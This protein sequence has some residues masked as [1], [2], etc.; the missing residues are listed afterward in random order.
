[1]TTWHSIKNQFPMTTWTWPSP[2]PQVGCTDKQRCAIILWSAHEHSEYVLN[3][4]HFCHSRQLHWYCKAERPPTF[5]SAKY[6][7]RPR[8]SRQGLD[9]NCCVSNPRSY[10][11]APKSSPRKLLGGALSYSN[12]IGIVLY[13]FKNRGMFPFGAK[14][15]R[16]HSFHSFELLLLV[17]AIFVHCRLV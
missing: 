2:R 7:C 15:R 3:I 13:S 16:F 6:S 1:M 17:T 10:Y 8:G 14:L 9:S 5:T 4:W 12:N 11:G